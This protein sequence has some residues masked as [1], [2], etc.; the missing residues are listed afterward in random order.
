MMV[1]GVLYGLCGGVPERYDPVLM[2]RRCLWPQF[3]RW[4]VSIPYFT[5]SL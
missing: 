4:C 5:Y 2:E 3:V 1:C